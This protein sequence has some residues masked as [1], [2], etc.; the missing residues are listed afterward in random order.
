MS[1]IQQVYSR[2]TQILHKLTAQSGDAIQTLY[3]PGLLTPYDRAPALRF[4]GFI[5]DLRVNINI[6]SLAESELPNIDLGTSRTDRVAA[7]RDLEWN[8]PRKQLDIYLATSTSAGWVNIATLSLLNRRPFYIV[9]LLSYVST[10]VAFQIANDAK[11]GVSISDV[12]YGLLEGNDTVTL[13]G[14]AK[15]EITAIPTESPVITT[16]QNYGAAI[17][18]TSRSV[19]S[20]NPARKQATFINR[21]NSETIWLSYA[22]VAEVGKGLELRPHGGAYE[23]N[24]SNPYKGA[25]A[26][27]ASGNANL[28]MLE[29]I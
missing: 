20:A 6:Q 3:Q 1:E 2:S 12:G 21:S 23:I 4:Y 29:A 8:S 16:A 19:L 18:S 13:F 7:V 15:E 26:A 17:T 28:A 25:I 22:P 10:N 11:L 5:T 27:I 24:F 14:A 9:N